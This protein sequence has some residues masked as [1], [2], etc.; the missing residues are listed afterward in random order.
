M[1]GKTS[2]IL[3]VLL[4]ALFAVAS[5]PGAAYGWNPF[6]K[7]NGNVK[8]GNK[9]LKKGKAGDALKKYAKALADHSDNAS[10]HYNTGVA[11]YKKA[12]KDEASKGKHLQEAV[13]SLVNAI[14]LAGEEE[15][16]LKA[17]AFYNLGNTYFSGERW[18]D[19]AGA[20]RQ[21]LKLRPGDKNA[22]HNL[23][24]AM[25]KI[26]EEKRKQEEEEE[27]KQKKQKKEEEEEKQ[28]R[29][30]QE[31][32]EEQSEEEEKKNDQCD[33]GQK[34]GEK[35]DQQEQEQDG[36]KSDQKKK[37]Q[38]QQQQ[39]QAMEKEKKAGEVEEKKQEAR[40]V[41]LTKQQLEAILDA[42]QSNEQNFQLETLRRMKG[43]KSKVLKDW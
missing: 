10:I 17:D 6:M 40:S 26:E 33:Q 18:Q 27:E 22:A 20:Y 3:Q 12:R 34:K 23:A 42:L 2:T 4:I 9:L 14:D 7:E 43:G 13:Q 36:Q 1:T 24:I 30:Q 16:D 21:S 29:D 31:E 37:Q 19:A 11:H 35:K 41:P 15:T 5:C 28:N 39:Q 38:Q 8:K 32:Q 25:N